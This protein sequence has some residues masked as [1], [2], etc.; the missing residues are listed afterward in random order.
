MYVIPTIEEFRQGKD[1]G[2]FYGFIERKF[3]A[4]W[5]KE[6]PEMLD[7]WDS[8]NRRTKYLL[9]YDYFDYYIINT[10]VGI[11]SKID[12]ETIKKNSHKVHYLAN[13]EKIYASRNYFNLS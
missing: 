4:F 10:M 11:G 13:N 6:S 8:E 9:N 3:Y 12:E 7:M 1:R 5:M 2:I